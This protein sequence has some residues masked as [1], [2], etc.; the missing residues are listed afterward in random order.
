LIQVNV[1]EEEISQLKIEIETLEENHEDEMN[2]LRLELNKQDEQEEASGP[3]SLGDKRKVLENS[4][5]KVVESRRQSSL[6][7]DSKQEAQRLQE[8]KNYIQKECDQLLQRR[9]RLQQEVGC[10]SGYSWGYGQSSTCMDTFLLPSTPQCQPFANQDKCCFRKSASTG[11]NLDFPAEDLSSVA[12]AYTV[13]K[14]QS[15]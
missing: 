12:H 6:E 15:T 10:Q 1:W 9:D 14:I 8:L 5:L 3:I 11:K 2:K 13:G 7:K 4:W